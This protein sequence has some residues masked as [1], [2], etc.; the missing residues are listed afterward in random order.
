MS[1]V[2]VK[3]IVDLEKQTVFS[4]K[5]NDYI[6]FTKNSSGY[7]TSVIKDKY[8]NIYH[9]LHEILYAEYHNLPKHLWPTDKN[10]KRFTINHK[11]HNRTDNRVENLELISYLD[12][13]DEIQKKKRSESVKNSERAREA[14]IRNFKIASEMNKKQVD[15]LD[16]RTG[17][18]LVSY[19][20]ITDAAKD[21]GA[22]V[23][24]I[25]Q[26][27]KGK[28]KSCKDYIWKNPQ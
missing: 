23:Q 16:K 2:F 28:I 21:V 1:N 13:C 4:L 7:F 20:S 3:H 14:S 9:S 18:I 24:N 22:F 15:K 8:G 10:G 25:C 12:Q 11:N 17:E 5:T 6:K 26:C 19:S 27:C